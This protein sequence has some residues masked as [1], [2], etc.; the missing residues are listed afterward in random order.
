M[1]PR[2][3]HCLSA[4]IALMLTAECMQ[5]PV[6]ASGAQPIGIVEFANV[7]T[8]LTVGEAPDFT[9]YLTGDALM[10][11]GIFNEGWG[12]SSDFSAYATKNG[13]EAIPDEPVGEPYTYVVALK[14]DAG[15][16]FPEDFSLYYNDVYIDPGMYT[17]TLRDEGQ[18]LM[19]LCRFIPEVIPV[20]DGVRTVSAVFI[21]DAVLSY[22]GSEAPC[23]TAHTVQNAGC[24]DY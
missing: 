20:Y 16:Y 23:F 13:G 4:G 21:E 17:A 24:T 8:E 22:G 5:I 1:K 12:L 9:A 19:L 3:P 18:T 14:A 2:I 6:S 10:H 15:W 11:A 7:S